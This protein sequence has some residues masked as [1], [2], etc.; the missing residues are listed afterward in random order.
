M[1]RRVRFGQRLPLVV[2][3]AALAVALVGTPMSEGAMRAVRTVL[4]A[5]NAGAVDGIKAS[6]LAHAGQLVP[7]NSHGHFSSSVL[8][9]PRGA[10]GPPGVQGPEGPSGITNGYRYGAIDKTI[11]TSPTN[12]ETITL[13]A[14]KYLVLGYA[15]L[16]DLDTVGTTGICDLHAVGSPPLFND[17][18]DYYSLAPEGTPPWR[19]RLAMSLMLDFSANGG[20]VEMTCHSDVASNVSA[21]WIVIN[22]LLI[23]SITGAYQST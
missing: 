3:L 15:N 18:E 9:I 10:Q 7:L 12:L 23:T 14:G 11:G 6:R 4:F 5:K 22:A 1:L 17:D 19:K 13:P 2:A 21:D 16:S 20:Q 8:A